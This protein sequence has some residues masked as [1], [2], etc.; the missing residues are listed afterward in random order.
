MRSTTFF[1]AALAIAAGR[2]M[3]QDPTDSAEGPDTTDSPDA[4]G[5]PACVMTCTMQEAPGAN[6]EMYV[7]FLLVPTDVTCLCASEAFQAA[8]AQCIAQTCSADDQA[9]ALEYQTQLCGSAEQ[10]AESISASASSAI[11]AI[12]S[13]ADAS[14]SSAP[15]ASVISSAPAESA[16]STGNAATALKMPSTSFLALGATALGFVVGPLLL[17][18]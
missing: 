15:S 5:I 6:C 9:A 11:P 3:A 17:F 18:A 10:P 4:T 16:S 1:I 14:A 7:Q 12:T 13:S 8:A 2:V